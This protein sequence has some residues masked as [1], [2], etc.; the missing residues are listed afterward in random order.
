LKVTVKLFAGLKELADAGQT[1]IELDNEATVA[2]LEERLAAEFPRLKPL[3][4][5]LAFAVNEEY[6][7]RDHALHDGDEIAV[8]PPISGGANV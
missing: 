5:S 6:C 8:I 3:L 4:P 7:A 1:T 2:D